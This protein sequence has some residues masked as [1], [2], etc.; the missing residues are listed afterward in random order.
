MNI[1]VS[2]TGAML[3][4]SGAGSLE[5]LGPDEYERYCSLADRPVCLNLASAA[6]L[7]SC[8]LFSDYQ[9]ASLQHYIEESGDILSI[10]EL[11]TVPGFTPELADALSHFVSLESHTPAGAR[12]RKR[13]RQDIMIRSSGSSLSGKYHAEAGERAELWLSSRERLTGSLAIYGKRPWK[14]VLGNFNARLGQGLLVWSGF[15]LSGF[16]ST[17]GFSKNASAFSATGS[18]SPSWRGMAAGYGGRSWQASLA[19][20]T[21]GHLLGTLSALGNS[22]SVA[23]NFIYGHGCKGISADWKKSFGHLSFFGEA[24]LAGSAA[25]LAGCSWDPAYELSGVLLARYYPSDYQAP[26][27]GAARSGSKTGDEAGISAGLRIRWFRA[28]ADMAFHPERWKKGKKNYQQFRSVLG[29]S[30]QFSAGSWMLSPSLRWTERMQL[31]PAAGKALPEW[32]HDLRFDLKAARN[33]LE[34]A[35]RLNGLQSGKHR[36][37]ALAYLEAGYA[38]PSDTARLRISIHLRGTVCRTDGWASRIYAYER[39]L[40]GRFN[41]PAWYGDM[42]GISA[43]ASIKYRGKRS[44]HQLD[45][46]VS[47]KD[48]RIQYSLRL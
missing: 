30:P 2:L 4:L 45:L 20:A 22:G 34:G 26:M 19:A 16:S 47:L 1:L 33:G 46:R 12:K 10:S 36:P 28:T 48:F 7:R 40:P 29:A 9:I 38:T 18:W 5:E 11:G 6:R 44:R 23:A 32:R 24:A 31:S 41:V 42:Y 14:L 27:A 3:L 17:S 13:L 35:L 15:S 8:G 25:F 21:D 37:G 43:V 39:D